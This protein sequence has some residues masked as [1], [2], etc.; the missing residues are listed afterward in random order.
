MGEQV[1]NDLNT[2]YNVDNDDESSVASPSIIPTDSG[3][4]SID[5]AKNAPAKA[6]THFYK[7]MPRLRVSTYNGSCWSSIQAFLRVTQSNIVCGQE[8]KL[9]P[10]AILEAQVVCKRLKLLKLLKFVVA[11]RRLSCAPM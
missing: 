11:L 1:Q 10:A 4:E 8:H 3:D 9:G 6:I 5:F 7:R 2:A